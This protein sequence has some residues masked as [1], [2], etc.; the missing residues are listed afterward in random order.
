MLNAGSCCCWKLQKN[1]SGQ[2]LH[3]FEPV[4]VTGRYVPSGHCCGQADPRGQTCA[5][6]QANAVG[7]DWPL[8]QKNPGAQG[9]VTSVSA[10]DAQYDPGVQF[11]H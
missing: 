6:R 10:V 8:G 11:V 9:P 7:L 4:D 3:V 5:A 1:P 2:G